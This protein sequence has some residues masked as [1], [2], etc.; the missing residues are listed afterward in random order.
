MLQVRFPREQTLRQKFQVGSLLE[1][2]S[3]DQH[4]CGKRRKLDRAKRASRLWC[5]LSKALAN[6]TGWVSYRA[7]LHWGEGSRLLWLHV[8]LSLIQA[9]PS[10]GMWPWARRLSLAEGNFQKGLTAEGCWQHIWSRQS[11]SSVLNGWDST[12]QYPLGFTP[13]ATACNPLFHITSGRGVLQESVGPLSMGKPYKR[14]L[15]GINRGPHY[16]TEL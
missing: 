8:D 3:Q 12:S 6:P 13:S 16:W 14:K 10:K 2:Y 5:D 11:K 7:V 4:L 1:E 15:S 9:A